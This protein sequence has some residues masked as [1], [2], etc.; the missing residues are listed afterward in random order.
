MAEIGN[1]FPNYRAFN[2]YM[3][4]LPISPWIES[5]SYTVA[6]AAA[7]KIYK[8]PGRP[9]ARSIRV[10]QQRGLTHLKGHGLVSERTCIF[11]SFRVI[12]DGLQ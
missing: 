12:G 8:L 2:T 5:T 6:A 9:L 11:G 4:T 7:K 10:S 3:K 1:Y